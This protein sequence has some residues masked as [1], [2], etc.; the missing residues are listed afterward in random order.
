MKQYHSYK[1]TDK[2]KWIYIYFM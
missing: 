1:N 2:G